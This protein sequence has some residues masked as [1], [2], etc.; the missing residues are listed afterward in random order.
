MVP[1]LFSAWY[2]WFIRHL[3]WTWLCEWDSLGGNLIFPGIFFVTALLSFPY[4]RH[5][6]CGCFEL[7]AVVVRLKILKYLIKVEWN[8]HDLQIP[9]ICRTEC[10]FMQACERCRMCWLKINHEIAV[11]WARNSCTGRD[12]SP[13]RKS[14]PFCNSEMQYLQ[15]FEVINLCFLRCSLSS[16]T[17]ACMSKYMHV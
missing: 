17:L 13:W 14:Q 7:V 15:K 3:W 8:A 4:T 10:N 12:I 5:N 2:V 9:I 11:T 16:L 1:V 6:L